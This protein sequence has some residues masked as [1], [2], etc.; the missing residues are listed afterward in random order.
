M[1]RK[2][3]VEPA[4]VPQECIERARHKAPERCIR[5]GEKSVGARRAQRVDK[6]GR[7]QRAN[8]CRKVAGFRRRVDDGLDEV[9]P[10]GRRRGV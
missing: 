6:R 4:G 2:E 10:D 5:R 3:C 7:L 1:V 8:Q 9:C